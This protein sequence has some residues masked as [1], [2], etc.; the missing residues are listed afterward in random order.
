MQFL[1][2]ADLIITP[3]FIIFLYFYARAIQKRRIDEFPEYRYYLL[4]L[5]VK[6]GGGIS[7]GLIYA[8][9]YGGGDATQYYQD[10]V[11]L[12][13]LQFKDPS[14]F[15]IV[16][17]DGLNRANY[18]YFDT[19]TGF[20]VYFR[21]S[22]TFF[23]VRIVWVA[24]LLGLTSFLGA[25][26]MMAWLSFEGIWR[27]YKV[28]IYEFPM[29][30]RQ[31]AIAILF[32]PS[33]FF[34]G[35]GLLKDTITFSCIGYFTYSFHSLFI[36]KKNIILNAVI[37][38]ISFY[39]ILSIKPYLVL[40]LLP[41]SL[42]WVTSNLLGKLKGSIIKVGSAPL[43]VV[44]SIVFGYLMLDNLNEDLGNYSLDKVLQRAVITQLD[45]KSDYYKGNSFDIGAFEPTMQGMLSKAPQAIAAT[46]FRP[47]IFEVRNIV[48]FFS[49]LEN[50]LILLFTIKVLFRVRIFG[51]LRYFTAHHLLTF[52]LIFSLFLAFAI[53]IS[54]SNFGSLV[55]YKIPAMPFYVASLY[56]ISYLDSLR[57]K[58]LYKTELIDDVKDLDE[59]ETK[60]DPILS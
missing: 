41:G 4:G 15:F 33:V 2:I 28:F 27:L 34:W 5:S 42:L 29:L 57:D 26:I 52:S 54:T 16:M 55:R 24:V 51:L 9:Y 47:T 31:M 40:G 56:I 59:S 46:L 25:T 53:G 32:I 11:C 49:G 14:S 23:V 8:L 45:L 1:S 22:A 19:D 38:Y 12:V 58:K 48:M 10:A 21:D 7:L 39:F 18:I 60:T 50:A 13:K 17:R 43:L 44:F 20:P 6:I 36:R 30:K 35:S 37:I 3:I